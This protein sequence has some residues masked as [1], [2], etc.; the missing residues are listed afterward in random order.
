MLM[1]PYYAKSEVRCRVKHRLA[2]WAGFKMTRRFYL[3]RSN[4]F[5]SGNCA[6]VTGAGLGIGRAMSRRF[7][8]M[9]LS[10]VMADLASDDLDEAVAFARSASLEE[11]SI[12]EAL[13]TDVSDPE[14]IR[15][16]QDFT[17]QRFGHPN[18]L[19]NN[20]VSRVGR[21]FIADLADWRQAMDVNLW[22]PINMVD[23]FMPG[24]LAQTEPAA[25]I[26][27]GSKQG[28]TNPP[29]HPVYNMAKAAVKSFTESLAHDLR[30]TQ[31]NRISAHLLVPGWTTTGLN[32]HKQGA[33]LPDQVS[34][35]MMNAISE[36][37]FYIICPDDETS[38]KMDVAR[39]LWS[40]EDITKNR[41]ALSRWH[42]AWSDTFKRTEQR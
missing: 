3:S 40:A 29:G 30:Q 6:V 5:K 7:A 26:N 13:P 12:I 9:G 20:A 19:V 24:L 25:I 38:E 42:A 28:I 39:I 14:Q 8:E 36:D 10:V 2:G 32:Q 16:L 41:P 35:Y 22:G 34:D 33:W 21:G 23:V 27:V 31:G 17:M 37:R 15:A 4:I 18:V 1:G 11:A